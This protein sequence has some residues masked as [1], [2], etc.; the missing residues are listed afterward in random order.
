IYDRNE[1][2]PKSNVKKLLLVGNS[3]NT[4][5]GKDTSTGFTLYAKVKMILSFMGVPLWLRSWMNPTQEM[6]L[7][8]DEIVTLTKEW[9]KDKLE[10]EMLA[11]GKVFC[12]EAGNWIKI[13]KCD[14]E[15]AIEKA[16]ADIMT[17][18]VPPS[19]TIALDSTK[20]LSHRK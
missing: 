20:A 6:Y 3:S 2:D 17:G 13:R 16:F 9:G 4:A 8:F 7:I 14:N 10:K 12:K 11:F 18:A 5:E 19:E 15:A 1:A